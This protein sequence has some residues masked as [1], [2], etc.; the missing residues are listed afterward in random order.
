MQIPY[1]IL[2]SY[3]FCDNSKKKKKKKKKKDQI[4]Q[5]PGNTLN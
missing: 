5:I 3:E 1:R 4:S 2:R